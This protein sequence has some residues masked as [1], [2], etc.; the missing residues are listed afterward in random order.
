MEL[1]HFNTNIFSEYIFFHIHL[2][3][4]ICN[5]NY[6]CTSLDFPTQ[7]AT[8]LYNVMSTHRHEEINV[9][10]DISLRNALFI[11]IMVHKYFD[12]T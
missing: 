12:I 7:M 4:F 9:G 8:C 1:G 3:Y 6:V 11:Y 10:S 5:L 2:F